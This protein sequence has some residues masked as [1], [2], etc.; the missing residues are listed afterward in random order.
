[1]IELYNDK[2]DIEVEVSNL[3]WKFSEDDFDAYLTKNKIEYVQFEYE[4]DDRDRF[5]G[6]VY[7]SVTKVNADKLCDHHGVQIMGRN[8]KVKVLKPEITHQDDHFDN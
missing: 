3:N 4:Y 8:I 7:L 2:Q 1:M 5:T 6:R